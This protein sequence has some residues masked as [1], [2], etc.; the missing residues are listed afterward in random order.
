ML[1]LKGVITQLGRTQSELAGALGVSPATLAQICNHGL[2]PKRPTKKAMQ[3]AICTALAEYGASTA[4]LATVFEPASVDATPQHTDEEDV[5]ML[6]RKQNLY[7][8]TRKHFGL[9]RDPFGELTSAEDVWVS[10]EVRYIRAALAQVA[11][12]ETFMAIV[13]ES[14]AGKS[15]LRR[16]LIERVQS[17]GLPVIVIEPYV[18]G[19][20]ENDIKG[21]T[22]KATDIAAAIIRTLDPV[23]KLARTAEGRFNQVHRALRESRRAGNRHVLII[24]E[25]HGLSIP[26]LKHLKRFYEL[27]DGFNRLL[28]IVLIGQTELGQKLSESNP[29]VREV[30]QRCEVVHLAPLDGHLEDYLNH[31]LTRAGKSL[32][33]VINETGV[34]AIR[35]RLTLPSHRGRQQVSLLYPLAVGNLIT[36]AMNL[37]ADIGAPLVDADVVKGLMSA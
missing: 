15:T 12:S 27:E 7:Q 20:E 3:S 30:V 34:E 19:L 18:L 29:V 17:E 16:D 11:T 37:A 5:E 8:Q 2:W 26:T 23:A 13:G 36:A 1:N 24:E 4:T 6:L 32:G 31:R 35:A 33:D 22:L 10:P 25:A 28:S 14:G 9:F 21:K